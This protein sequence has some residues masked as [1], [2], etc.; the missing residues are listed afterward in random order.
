[1]DGVGR[2]CLRRAE[3][4]RVQPR[5][6]LCGYGWDYAFG[7]GWDYGWD[8]A[9]ARGCGRSR[10]VLRGT[11]TGAVRHNDGGAGEGE[12]DPAVSV[13]RRGERER[14]FAYTIRGPGESERGPAGA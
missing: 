4:S 7:Y 12:R 8:C 1:V 2:D 5:A 3:H 13:S 10:A 6:G 14:R 9:V 11:A